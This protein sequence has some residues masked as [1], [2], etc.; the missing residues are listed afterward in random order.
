MTFM[1]DEERRGII[2]GAI[3]AHAKARRELG[4]LRAKASAWSEQLAEAATSL[5]IAAKSERPEDEPIGRLPSAAEVTELLA[6]IHDMEARA[7]DLH[8]QLRG[9]GVE[10]KD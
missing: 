6:A 1:S 7:A 10:L 5:R 2:G 3:E 9:M 4:V 8:G